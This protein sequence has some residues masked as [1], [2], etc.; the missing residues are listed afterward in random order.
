M[1]ARGTTIPIRVEAPQ[2]SQLPPALTRRGALQLMAASMAL[3][4]GA[5]SRA[6][7]HRIHP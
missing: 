4:G 6:P 1:S 7:V 3:A 5:C 2:P